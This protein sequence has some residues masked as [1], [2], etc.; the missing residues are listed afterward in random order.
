MFPLIAEGQRSATSQAIYQLFGMFVTLVLAIV[1]GSLGG[2]WPW[3]AVG[4]WQEL[5]GRVNT[6]ERESLE[7]GPLSPLSLAFDSFAHRY[8]LNA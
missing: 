8:L 1:G 6:E 7:E 3:T 5:Q 2:E 4:D